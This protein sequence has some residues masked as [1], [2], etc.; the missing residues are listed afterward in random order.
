MMWKK[1]E[2]TFLWSKESDKPS[3]LYTNLCTMRQRGPPISEQTK[4]DSKSRRFIELGDD[5][6]K[7]SNWKN[8]LNSYSRSLC[9]ATSDVYLSYGFAKRSRCF[10]NTGMYKACLIDID[11][12]KRYNYENLAELE[13]RR[14]NCER[15]MSE[16]VKIFTPQLSFPSH[17]QFPGLAN[18]LKIERNHEFGLHVTATADI[19]VGR[20]VLLEKAFIAVS[21]DTE[22][23]CSKCFS[24]QTN[25]VPC[26]KCA[27]ALFCVGSCEICDIHQLEC[28]LQ[29]PRK[30]IWIKEDYYSIIRS[31]IV[32]INM[33]SSIEELKNFV[34]NVIADEQMKLPTNTLD[35]HSKYGIILRH[36]NKNYPDAS[37]TTKSNIQAIYQALMN[38]K[39]IGSK[40][41][42]KHHQR[43]LMHLIGHH[44]SAW[45][46][47][48]NGA[49]GIKKLVTPVISGYFNHSCMPNAIFLHIDGFLMVKTCRPIRTGQQIFISYIGAKFTD[50]FIQRQKFFE[51]QYYF[52]CKCERCFMEVTENRTPHQFL[53]AQTRSQLDTCIKPLTSNVE[54]RKKHAEL[55]VR[56]LNEHGSGPWCNDLENLLRNYYLLLYIKFMFKSTY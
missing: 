43:F 44:I 45:R 38:H 55:Y 33:F 41:K 17:E 53:D 49:K 11:L 37:N 13:Q 47:I 40:F 54:W 31:I 8:A 20:T 18:M 48:T 15:D 30:S 46:N 29:F 12:A 28:G 7:K 36:F 6:L 51:D 35:D 5:E 4:N 34:E 19:D 10:Y 2:N 27:R 25:L 3:A 9:F 1:K 26:K 32:V 42:I 50:T 23:R 14:K 21:N 52:K 16:Q 24:S 56:L 39:P 22:Q